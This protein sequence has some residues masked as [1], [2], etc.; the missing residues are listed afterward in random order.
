MKIK[1]LKIYKVK[2]CYIL[3]VYLLKRLMWKRCRSQS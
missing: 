1:L 3:V 2:L